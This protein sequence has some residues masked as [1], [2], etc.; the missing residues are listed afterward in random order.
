MSTIIKRVLMLTIGAGGLLLTIGWGLA[1]S[2]APDP[3]NPIAPPGLAANSY[4]SGNLL[5]NADFENGWYQPYAE[6]NSIRVPVGWNIRWY[7]DMAI[8]GYPFGQPETS[9][10]DPVW[11]N[12]CADNYPPRIHSGDHAFESGKQWSPQDVSLYQSV[13]GIPIGAEVIGSA[14]LHAWVSSCNPNPKDKPPEMALSLLGPNTD[15]ESNCLPGFWDINSSHLQVGIDPW[16]GTNPRSAQ[17]VWNWYGDNP[18]WWGPYDYYSNTVPVTAVAQ[19]HTVTLFLRGV[20]ISPPRFNAIYMDTASLIYRTTA[21]L[22]TVAEPWWPLPSRVTVTLHV[23]APLTGVDISATGPTG[24]SVP[25]SFL[26]TEGETPDVTLRW[27]FQTDVPGRYTLGLNAAE[28]TAPLVKTIEVTSL[29]W[30]ATQNRLMPRDPISST[31]MITEPV[32]IS[33]TLH[34]PRVVAEPTAALVDPLG[35][36]LTITFVSA[37][38]TTSGLDYGWIFTPVLTGAHTIVLGSLDFIKPYT[39]T[40]VAAT[41]WVFLPIVARY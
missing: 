10:L 20:T 41:D 13:G 24:V 16:G 21:T 34:T 27:T 38:T 30:G 18:P 6:H 8:S 15:D 7:T 5:N 40:A 25:V 32:V 17:V 28:L 14:W 12:C 31:E 19:A 35:E 11:P 2:A 36:P 26:G 22:D 3:A 1:R 39:L 37:V 4:A 23:P 9:V 29:P 33:L